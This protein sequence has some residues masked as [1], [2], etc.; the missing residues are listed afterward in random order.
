MDAKRKKLKED[1]EARED[2]YRRST[3]GTN[4][5]ATEEERFKAE[6]ERLRKE[7]SRQVEEEIAL[8]TKRISEEL[9]EKRTKDGKLGASSSSNSYRLK[10]K[11]KIDK[12]QSNCTTYD[13]ESLYEIFSKYGRIVA[14]VVSPVGKGRAII[15][16][17]SQ[18]DAEV[19]ADTESG[20]ASSPLVIEKLWSKGTG[21]PEEKEKTPKFFSTTAD[22]QSKSNWKN[23]PPVPTTTGYRPSAASSSASDA[24]EKRKFSDAEFEELVL[25]N[26]R[27]AQEKKRLAASTEKTENR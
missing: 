1:L 25:A 24:S 5:S 9:R 17:E 14:M 11:W 2:A 16:F 3:D 20:Y 23:V 18:T 26:L 27:K 4:Y 12:T 6:V 21:E 13:R 15:E 22:N 8:V 19:A 7:G 10:I